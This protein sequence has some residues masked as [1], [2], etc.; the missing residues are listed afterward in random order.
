MTAFTL[1]T[2]LIFYTLHRKAIEAVDAP[3]GIKMAVFSSAMNFFGF[4][5]SLIATTVHF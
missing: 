3:M 4:L 2:G 5:S 1:S